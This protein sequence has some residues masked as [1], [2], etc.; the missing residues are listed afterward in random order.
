MIPFER[1]QT[2]GYGAPPGMIRKKLP[3]LNDG[4]AEKAVQE[5]FHGSAYGLFLHQEGFGPMRNESRE[6]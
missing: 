3:G 4:L 1:C 2:I 6:C 5:P